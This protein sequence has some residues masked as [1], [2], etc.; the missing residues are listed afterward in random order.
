MLSLP[1]KSIINH[2]QVNYQ[3]RMNNRVNLNLISIDIDLFFKL[4]MSPSALQ[5]A[6]GLR[7]A[8]CNLK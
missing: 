2:Y 1:I 5:F 8:H 6:R 4:V 7:K 3:Y